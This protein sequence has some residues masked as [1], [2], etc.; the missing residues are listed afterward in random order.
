MSIFVKLNGGF[1]DQLK[2]YLAASFI[3]EKTAKKLVLI[4][5]EVIGDNDIK[6][7]DTRSSLLKITNIQGLQMVNNIIFDDYDY[8]SVAGDEYNKATL[9][10]NYTSTSTYILR[11]QSHPYIPVWD[12]PWFLINTQTN[13]IKNCFSIKNNIE[14]ELACND[15][16]ENIVHQFCSV[17][18]LNWYVQNL[19][20]LK[21]FVKFDN[22]S[23]PS[24]DNDF[25]CVCSEDIVISVRLGGSIT[26]QNSFCFSDNEGSLRIPFEYYKKAIDFFGNYKRILICSDNYDSD[27]ITQ[28]NLYPNIIFLKNFNTL[29]QFKVILDCK[30]F[31]SSNSSFSIMGSIFSDSITTFPK[32]NNHTV[33]QDHIYGKLDGNNPQIYPKKSTDVIINI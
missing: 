25:P 30:R 8:C 9:Y 21:E 26:E 31:V 28:F 11:R 33:R 29:E 22:L 14:F 17:D 7:Q 18:H 15:T 32:V 4:S 3:A 2:I 12:W 20:L 16:S 5:N 6:R 19:N 24:L 27:Y 10:S 13:E 23:Y 1:G